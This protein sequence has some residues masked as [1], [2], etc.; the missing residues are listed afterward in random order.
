MQDFEKIYRQYFSDVY[1]Y[2]RRL[3]GD[4]RLA[5]DITADAFF[6]AMNA[7]D[8]FRGDCDVRIWLC[9]IARN[10]WYDHLKKARRHVD[11]ENL[12]DIPAP[13][14][15]TDDRDDAAAIRRAMHSLPDPYREVFMWRTL[16]EMSYK[17]IAAMFGKSENWACV[18]CHRARKMI[19]QSLEEMNDEK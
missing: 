19:K 10:L 2:M 13:P 15:F 7:I 18:V 4:E 3:T 17:D 9:R 16:G 11:P 6:K 5:E 14:V 1:R 12:P 8:S